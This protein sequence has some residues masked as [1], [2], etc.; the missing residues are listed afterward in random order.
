LVSLLLGNKKINESNKM[1]ITLTTLLFLT[2][3]TSFSQSWET[4]TTETSCIARSENSVVEINN[5]IIL[6]GGRGIKP[7]EMFD[8]KTKSW[9]KMAETPIEIHHFQAVPYK[10]ELWVLCGFTGGYPHET[11]IPNIYIFNPEKNEWR[12]GAEIPKD[13][14]R[15]SAGVFVYKDKIYV[16]CGIQDGHWDGHVAWMDEFDPKTNTWK[17]LPDA[18]HSRDHLQAVEKD[19]K[20][21][22]A[23]GRRS[24][25]KTNEVLTLTEPA[26][27]IF[28][29]KTNSWTTLSE[30][31]NIP[32]QRA[33]V[34]CVT[35]NNKILVFGGESGSQIPAH[36]EVEALDIQTL[37][38]E[39]YPNL[40]RGRHG[41]GAIVH[42][43]KVYTMAGCGNRGGSPELNSVEVLK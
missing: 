10:K 14:Q 35:L 22:I 43:G 31:Q 36:S 37:K 28:D 41:T 18:P 11:P 27:D 17:K 42:K 1:K 40:Q 38:W 19:G 20:V 12:V 8:L 26:V 6:V 23:G 5:K 9:V 3:I 32:T 39:K 29:F 16:V 30:N 2:T 13:R 15:G 25:A 21:Y 7:V 24:R 4:L 33:G 34:S